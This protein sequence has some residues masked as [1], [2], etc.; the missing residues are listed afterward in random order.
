MNKIISIPRLD[1]RIIL[2]DVNAFSTYRISGK[3]SQQQ[4]IQSTPPNQSEKEVL[5]DCRMGIDTHVNSSCAGKHVR[6]IEFIDGK[7]YKVT[8]FNK[9]YEP[10]N[11]I[12]MINGIV[13]VESKDGSGNI[14]GLNNFLNFTDMMKHTILVPMQARENRVPIDDVPSRLCPYNKSTQSIYF[15]EEIARIPVEFH[16]PI[17]F[18]RIRIILTSNSD[19]EPYPYTS[20]VSDINYQFDKLYHSEI[21]LYD[22]AY[23]SINVSSIRRKGKSHELTAEMLSRMWSISLRAAKRTLS[24]TSNTSIRS[25]EG[26]LTRR[27]RTNVCQK[28][29]RVLGG[30][31]SPF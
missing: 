27:Y 12:S 3:S 21:A 9:D 30:D 7:K 19:W 8:P 28:H 6:I 31:F 4:K 16:R 2:R 18:I 23:E 14:L 24:S 20:L 1:G 11:N 13:A 26:H 22:K 17:S 10:T 5:E 15:P 25:N 29:Y